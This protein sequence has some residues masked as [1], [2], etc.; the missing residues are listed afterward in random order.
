M[1][2]QDL[3]NLYTQPLPP[4]SGKPEV[5]AS[6]KPT[7]IV[8]GNAPQPVVIDRAGEVV[9]DMGDDEMTVTIKE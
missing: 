2:R 4:K 9:V 5:K 6:A 3:Y 7:T 8:V 1:N